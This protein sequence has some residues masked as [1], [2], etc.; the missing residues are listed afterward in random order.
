MPEP[1]EVHLE[2]L[3]T[4]SWLRALPDTLTEPCGSGQFRFVVVSSTRASSHT[5]KD[6]RAFSVS[7]PALLLQDP[8]GPTQPD[9]W[10]DV[11]RQR[12]AD[13]DFELRRAG[14]RRRPERGRYWWSLTY[15]PAPRP[16]QPVHGEKDPSPRAVRLGLVE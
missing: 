14:W 7:F 1:L 15:D 9:A 11:A 2:E 8:E 13:L 4:H 3:D 10:L 12:L 16:A 5:L 6:H